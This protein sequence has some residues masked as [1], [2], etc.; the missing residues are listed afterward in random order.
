M[1]TSLLSFLVLNNANSQ[2]VT[3]DETT[4]TTTTSFETTTTVT[5]VRSTTTSFTTVEGKKK[6]L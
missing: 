5:L 1:K 6:G 4:G 2:A 3:P